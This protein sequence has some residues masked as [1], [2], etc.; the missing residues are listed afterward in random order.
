MQTTED[1][2]L[3][4]EGLVIVD[5]DGFYEEGETDGEI[6]PGEMDNDDERPAIAGTWPGEVRPQVCAQYFPKGKTSRL[7]G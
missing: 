7:S 2:D 5:R 4:L 3:V 6:A 1:A